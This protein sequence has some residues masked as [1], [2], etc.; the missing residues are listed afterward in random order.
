MTNMNI[1]G[2]QQTGRENLGLFVALTESSKPQFG[3]VPVLL[4]SRHSRRTH[5]DCQW[6]GRL[7]LGSTGG[8]RRD[9]S[10]SEMCA[11]GCSRLERTPAA[12]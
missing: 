8:I 11:T 5:D 2:T 3:G 7:L 12:R 10:A 9:R 1:L 4:K 6:T